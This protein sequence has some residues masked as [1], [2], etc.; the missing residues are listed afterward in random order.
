MQ[1]YSTSN[2]PWGPLAT[3]KFLGPKPKIKWTKRQGQGAEVELQREK[4]GKKGNA[5]CRGVGGDGSKSRH[6][7]TGEEKEKKNLFKP[8]S[9]ALRK[10]P[11]KCAVQ[12]SVPNAERATLQAKNEWERS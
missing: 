10:R 7:A 5:R 2:G 1:T 6:N 8:K 11:T 12:A 4:E 3:Q 9:V